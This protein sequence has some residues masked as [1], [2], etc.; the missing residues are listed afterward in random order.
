MLVFSTGYYVRYDSSRQ[1]VFVLCHARLKSRG[2]YP[3]FMKAFDGYLLFM[4]PHT[5]PKNFPKFCVR[6]DDCTLGKAL[7]HYSK[8][9]MG[10][11]WRADCDKKGT[12]RAI[13]RPLGNASKI[14]VNA[15]DKDLNGKVATITDVGWY[16]RWWGGIH[17]LCGDEGFE[18]GIYLMRPSFEDLLP[19]GDWFKLE[20]RYKCRI[21]PP[22]P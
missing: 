14:W 3:E 5:E 4:D 22:R 18:D 1:Q 7:D 20:P 13:R 21:Q 10:K 11:F 6:L 8:K 16:Y 19:P 15:G 17:L 2:E 9:E 12:P